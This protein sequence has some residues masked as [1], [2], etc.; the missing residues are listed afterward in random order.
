MNRPYG[1]VS[2]GDNAMEI[3]ERESVL[4][5]NTETDIVAMFALFGTATVPVP[6]QMIGVE[7]I[8]IRSLRRR[9]NRKR[10]LHDL[11]LEYALWTDQMHSLTQECEAGLQHRVRQHLPTVNRTL[12]T[13]PFECGAPN[14]GIRGAL[15]SGHL[16]LPHPVATTTLTPGSGSRYATE[17]RRGRAA[18]GDPRG[19]E[20]G[21]R[22]TCSSRARFRSRP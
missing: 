6:K 16:A 18:G 11:R 19:L 14:P 9:C 3:R 12:L 17:G 21:C 2:S 20:S 10:Y 5:R 7:G 8:V 4:H 13:E 15:K 22:A 1:Q